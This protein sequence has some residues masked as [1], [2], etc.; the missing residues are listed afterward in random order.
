MLFSIVFSARTSY[1]ACTYRRD[2]D[3]YVSR[4][5]GSTLTLVPL[6]TRRRKHENINTRDRVEYVHGLKHAGVNR[7][8]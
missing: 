4:R 3:S 6:K 8:T 5:N 1:N 2:S 7:V